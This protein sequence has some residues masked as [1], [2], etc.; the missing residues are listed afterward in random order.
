MLALTDE[1]YTISLETNGALSTQ[2]VPEA[3]HIILDI[4]CPGSGMAH[5][6]DWTNVERLRCHDEVKFVIA[7]RHDYEWAKKITETHQLQDKAGH[8]LFSPVFGELAAHDLISWITHDRLP[9]RL[10][11]QTHKFIWD[12]SQRGV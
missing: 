6:T 1:Q 5:A 4:K 8:V 2:D 10:N 7:D 3:V 9:V 12:P 11:L